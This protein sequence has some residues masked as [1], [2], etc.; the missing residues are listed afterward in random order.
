MVM[1]KKK[2]ILILSLLIVQVISSVGLS[3]SIHA[4]ETEDYIHYRLGIKFKNE[5]NLEQAL[6][7]FRKVLTSYPDNYNAYMQIAE[8]RKTQNQPGLEIYALKKALAYN[9]EWGRARLMLAD[10]Y[11]ADK[12]Y[13]NAI[14][15]LQAYQQSC[16]PSE[17]DDI[18]K[19]IDRII[20]E[21]QGK[22]TEKTPDSLIKSQ[23]ASQHGAGIAKAGS[24]ASKSNK[25][26]VEKF[27]DAS[28]A[29]NRAM[30]LYDLGKTEEALP[31][32]KKAILMRP[33]YPEAY[34]DAGLMRFKLR[35]FDLAKI[36]FV[37]AASM[38]ASHYYIGKIYGMEKYY[39]GA[40]DELS[41]Y[42]VNA[43]EGDLKQDAVKL[44]VEYK[45]VLNDTTALSAAVKIAEK[46]DSSS[47]HVE[48][49]DTVKPVPDSAYS[50]IE[51]KADSL[52]TMQV[53]DT[54]TNP[55]QAMLAGVNEYKNGK[56]EQA[57][58]EF[59]KVM[60]SYTSVNITAP[61]MYNTG[62][63]YLKLRLFQNADNQFDNLRHRYPSHPLA[64]QSLL[65]KAFSCFERGEMTDCEKM[66]REFITRYRSHPWICQAYEKLGDVYADMKV[67][68]KS[69]DAYRLAASLAKNGADQV[70]AYYKLGIVCF[71]AGN[72]E[73][74]V[75][76]FT[77]AI[78]TGETGKFFNR[79]P[80]SYYK[81]ADYKYQQ[82]DYKTALEY[83]QKVTRKY[84]EFQETPWGLFQ[85]GNIYK[86]MGDYHKAIELYKELTARYPDDYWAKQA[87]WKID[88]AVWENEYNAVLK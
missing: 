15:E 10:A 40:V 57:V 58:K 63:C 18:Q 43:P 76:S 69:M 13:Q 87:K 78:E 22:G 62:I 45:R 27:H 49:I 51:M 21:V 59:K 14:M 79:V 2:S 46:Q 84:P 33:N 83:Y 50:I 67:Y 8:I 39:K 29:L 85:I 5:N 7:E 44:L 68:N 34:F 77:K 80:E 4:E 73:Q 88:D 86:N 24:N 30:Q 66:L 38:P 65:L 26:A 52:M 70:A 61:C 54:L 23:E 82:K 53:V 48:N 42:V 25:A 81:I 20:K 28:T 19:N 35:Q 32:V 37:K 55:G 36:N 31:Y 3:Y 72:T 11:D 71:D 41:K 60:A 47:K 75:I 1:R 6:E 17:R 74:A 64:A 9:P 56:Y 16:D 12:Q